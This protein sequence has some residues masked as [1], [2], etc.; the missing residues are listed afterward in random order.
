M[1]TKVLGTELDKLVSKLW[2]CV[3]DLHKYTT[4]EGG[5]GV[6]VHWSDT[7]SMLRDSFA[8]ETVTLTV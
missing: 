6:M 1:V 2:F 5:V 3:D 4:G 8:G 7:T